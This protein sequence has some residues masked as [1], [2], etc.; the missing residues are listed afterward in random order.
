MEVAGEDGNIVVRFSE[1]KYFE[2]LDA[3]PELYP[4]EMLKI[5]PEVTEIVVPKQEVVSKPKPKKPQKP[6]P[7]EVRV[8]RKTTKEVS[9]ATKKPE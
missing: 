5:D 3:L 2:V 6:D 8:R 4:V 7:E 9:I 1:V